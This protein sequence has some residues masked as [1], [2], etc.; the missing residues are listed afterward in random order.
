MSKSRVLGPFGIEGCRPT[1][2][3]VLLRVASRSCGDKIVL[4]SLLAHYTS[5]LNLANGVEK[6][7]L[8]LKVHRLTF[9]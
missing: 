7:R 3:S 9:I 8:F 5:N 4:A 2:N 6:L 1:S